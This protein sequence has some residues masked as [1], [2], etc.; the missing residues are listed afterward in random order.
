MTHLY[1]HN[2]IIIIISVHSHCRAYNFTSISTYRCIIDERFK[3]YLTYIMSNEILIRIGLNSF[4]HFRLARA[5]SAIIVLCIR[6]TFTR[7]LSR[8][9]IKRVTLFTMRA[10]TDAQNKYG[11]LS[12]HCL[13]IPSVRSIRA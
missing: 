11:V 1:V 8:T 5:G 3:E 4:S 13:R 9:Y 6:S 10:F 12:S 2:D 7:L